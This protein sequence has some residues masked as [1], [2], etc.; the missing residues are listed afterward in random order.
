MNFLMLSLFLGTTVLVELIDDVI[1]FELSE[2]TSKSNFIDLEF[3]L[4]KEFEDEAKKITVNN[5]L[6]FF[7]LK[8]SPYFRTADKKTSFYQNIQLP[9]PEL[10]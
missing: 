10:T 2:T 5:E 3:E 7:D 8:N 1:L 4:E 6:I 9:P